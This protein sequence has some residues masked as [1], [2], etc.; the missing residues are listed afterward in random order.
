[1]VTEGKPVNQ[2]AYNPITRVY[3][4]NQILDLLKDFDMI[5]LRKGSFSYGQLFPRGGGLVD[6]ALNFF[7]GARK[8]RGGLLVYGEDA[9]LQS[10]VERWIGTHL[11]F[12][13]NAL[14]KK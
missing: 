4:R 7:L 6:R 13:W 12:A 10:N 11:G 1:M 9:I 5:S 3:S 2:H 8:H 14:I